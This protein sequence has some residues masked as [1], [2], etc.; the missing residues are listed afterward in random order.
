MIEPSKLYDY[1]PFTMSLGLNR[2]DAYD[3]LHDVWIKLSQKDYEYGDR[4]DALIMTAIRNLFLDKCRSQKRL[5][6]R[7]VKYKR[8]I[9]HFDLQPEI[10]SDYIRMVRANKLK[11]FIKNELWGSR[12]IVFELY[13]KEK[14][15]REIGKEIGMN[16]NTVLATIRKT[17]I[18]LCEY[19]GEP[20]FRKRTRIAN[21]KRAA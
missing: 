1:L 19:F 14:T 20:R 10:D 11:E 4:S 12:R 2:Q 16:I 6:K 21:Y 8:E 18:A 7:I 5:E 15:A 13:L 3:L 17:K 9:E